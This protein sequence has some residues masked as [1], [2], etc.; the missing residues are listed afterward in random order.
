[1]I[2]IHH[3]RKKCIGCNTCVVM[4]PDTWQLSRKDGKAVLIGAKEKKGVFTRHEA[5]RAV[6]QLRNTA[7]ACPSRCIRIQ[8]G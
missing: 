7:L 2:R 4:D 6:L 5:H 1:M 3:Y 8:E